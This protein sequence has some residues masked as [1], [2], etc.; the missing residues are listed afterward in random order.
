[1]PLLPKIKLYWASCEF[2]IFLFI[3]VPVS[4]STSTIN[5]ADCIWTCTCH[6]KKMRKWAQ[7][8]RTYNSFIH[9]TERFVSRDI[10]LHSQT[11]AY[12]HS[13]FICLHAFSESYLFGVVIKWWRYRYNY[14]LS[15]WQPEW[16]EIKDT[17]LIKWLKTLEHMK[18]RL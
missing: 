4:R 7:I 18:Y 2:L 9:I 11:S 15:W 8:L 1:M 13:G 3:V 16:P 6:D 12:S 10:A 14:S 5:P 17:P